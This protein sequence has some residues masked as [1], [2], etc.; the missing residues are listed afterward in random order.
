MYIDPNYNAFKDRHK[1]QRA[2]VLGN[3]ASLN[4]VNLKKLK[5]ELIFGCNKIFL[6][7]EKMKYAVT[8]Y[9]VMDGKEVRQSINAIKK[10]LTLGK[11]DIR[12]MFMTQHSDLNDNEKQRLRNMVRVK[13]MPVSGFVKQY[14]IPH[15]CTSPI[16]IV[17][18]MIMG[19][20]PIYLL[21]VDLNYANPSIYVPINPQLNMWKLA[22]DKKDT[23]HFHPDYLRGDTFSYP[24]NDK[25]IL[26]H[27]RLAQFANRERVKIYVASPGGNAK[28]FERRKFEDAIK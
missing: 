26:S 1:G 22:D 28:M 6:N 12:N 14:G 4:K 23:V 27:F 3:G 19:C 17:M 16:M 13:P 24:N 11:N 10:Y 8:Y 21:G 20:T 5:K 7:Y 9:F 15:S 25:M 2:F 18:A